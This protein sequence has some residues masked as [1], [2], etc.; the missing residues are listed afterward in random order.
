MLKIYPIMKSFIKKLFLK[1]ISFW[2]IFILSLILSAY[3]GYLIKSF[4]GLKSLNKIQVDSTFVNLKP[5]TES[6]NA[7]AYLVGDLSNGK[8]L[9]ARNQNF[10]LYPA[11]LSKLMTGV[12]VMDQFS[13]EQPITITSYSVSAEGEEGGLQKGEIFTVNDLLKILLITSSNDAAVAFA[14]SLNKIGINFID[15]MNEKAQQWGM[16]NTAFFGETGLD[17][18]GNF[19]TAE[20]LFKLSQEIYQ[21]YPLLGEITRKAEDTVIPLNSQIHH[22]LINTNILVNQLP[23]LWLGKTG[24]TP[25]ARDCL[26]TIFEFPF[27]SD[28]IPIGIIVL[29]SN[30]RFDDT[31]KLYHWVQ[32]LLK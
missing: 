23:E 24:F 5:L 19:T 16:N 12:I 17:R 3:G 1:Q 14:E 20:D 32:E 27:K 29:S 31:L 30:D 25:G 9:M 4:Q 2:I 8:I 26:L 18:K 22:Q 13:L 11:S 28:K 10:H 7:T 6:L 15:L 21:H